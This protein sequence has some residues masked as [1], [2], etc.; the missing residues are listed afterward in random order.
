[1]AINLCFNRH[2]GRRALLNVLPRLQRPSHATQPDLA[3]RELIEALPPRERTLIVLH[4]GH[5]YRTD[6]LA[7]LLNLT[8]TNARTILFRA[9]ARLGRTMREAER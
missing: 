7:A 6:E 4:Y 5:G 8:P 9:R 1:M 2:R 3:L